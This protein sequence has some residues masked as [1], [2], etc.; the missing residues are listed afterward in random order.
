M[1]LLYSW[2]QQWS[3]KCVRWA[4]KEDALPLLY[5][6]SKRSYFRPLH[7]PQHRY[8]RLWYRSSSTTARAV[9][10]L[11]NEQ[12]YRL[13]LQ[14]L[15]RFWSMETRKLFGEK[16]AKLQYYRL[17]VPLGQYYR[18]HMS[19]T[20]AQFVLISAEWFCN[21]SNLVSFDHRICMYI[22]LTWNT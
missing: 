19:S 6:S 16:Y 12:Y 13:L 7:I 1:K 17:V 14:V 15:S 10:P 3:L 4:E 5:L 11:I 2:V 21:D 9:L 8:Y 20:T 22:I 18:L